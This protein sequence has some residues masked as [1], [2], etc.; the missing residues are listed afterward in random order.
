MI[1]QGTCEMKFWQFFY[2]HIFKKL[3]LRRKITAKGVVRGYGHSKMW[4][5]IRRLF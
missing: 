4:S 3:V 5:M 1:L 2:I